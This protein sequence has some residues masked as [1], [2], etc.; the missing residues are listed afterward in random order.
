MSDVF[1]LTRVDPLTGVAEAIPAHERIEALLEHPQAERLT[2]WL[3]LL[4]ERDDFGVK[5]MVDDMDP[6]IIV[7][8]LRAHVQIF[9][10][11]EDQDLLDAIDGPVMSSPDGVYALFLSDED[12]A[13]LTRHLLER[14]YAIDILVGHRFLEASRWEVTAELV[15]RAYTMREARLGDLGF[16]PFHEALEVYTWLP[17]REFVAKARARANS[18]TTEPLIIP[19]GGRLDPVD[20]QLQWLEQRRFSES[21]NIFSQA[22]GA[23]PLVVDA[24]QVED[25][26]SSLLSQ[27]RALANRAHTADRGNPGDMT[28]ARKA[29]QAAER[30]LSL[31]LEL[32]ADT[33][34]TLAARVL[35]TTPLKELH[36]AGFSAQLEIQRQVRR[37]VDRGQLTLTDAPMS[38][39]DPIDADLF[40]GLLRER[41]VMSATY[42]T[43]I[44]SMQDLRHAA[45]RVSEVAFQELALFGLLRHRHEEVSQLVF[46]PAKS[47]TPVE[48]VRFRSLFAT[49]LINDHLGRKDELQPLTIGE[50][51]RFGE[52]LHSHDNALETL[53]D[54]LTLMLTP[55]TEQA[56]D[57][58]PIATLLAGR[59]S[60]WIID[61]WGDTA[62]PLLAEIAQQLVLVTPLQ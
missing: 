51:H 41:P 62:Q 20:H 22:L 30:L 42:D 14:L 9:F 11:E 61:E 13:P 16:V 5:E 54:R 59:V 56:G 39:L 24:D 21:T 19:V 26:V 55:K 40:A 48:L 10:W 34:A 43:P 18:P 38:L 6:E 8:W 37:L 60:G 46:D 27:F 45:R 53:V 50:L 52:W 23:L 1:Q 57:L 2:N 25:V 12:L 33:D 58:A 36:R 29:T 47:G 49:R 17:P 4:L 31:G 15:E 32:A 7:A 35:S 44:G 3:R 28:S